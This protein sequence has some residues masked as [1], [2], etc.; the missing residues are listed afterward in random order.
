M[1]GINGI[2]TWTETYDVLKLQKHYK[3]EDK[4]KAWTETYDVLK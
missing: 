1:Q 3:S 2:K 4:Q